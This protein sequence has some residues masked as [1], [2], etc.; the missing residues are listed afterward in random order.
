LAVAFLLVP[1]VVLSAGEVIEVR[2][3]RV[4]S[5]CSHYATFQSHNQKVVRNEKGIFMTYLWQFDLKTWWGRWQLLRSTDG[6]RTFSVIYTSGE[7]GSNAPCIETDSEN[8]ILLV[9]TDYNAGTLPIYYYRFEADRNYTDPTITTIRN[10]ASGKFS[11][12]LDED[13]DLLYIFNHYGRLLVRN[14]TTG[15]YVRQREVVE[16]SGEYA[17]TQYPHVFVD[18]KGTVHH[19]WTTQKKDLYL[20]WDIHYINSP[21]KGAYWY[22]AAGKKLPYE[23]RPDDPNQT[24]VIVLDDEFQYH[25]WLSNMIVKNG[26]VHFA[27]LAQVPPNWRQHYVRLDLET[28]EIDKRIQPLFKGETISLNGLDGFFAT[29]PGSSPL[30]YVARANYSHIGALVSYDNGD[31]WHDAAISEPIPHSIYSV[32]GCRELA[33]EGIMGSFTAQ[34][35]T[36]PETIAGDPHFFVIPVAE[37]PALSAAAILITSAGRHIRRRR[38]RGG[39]GHAPLGC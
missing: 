4:D 10:G 20:Y 16:T 35:G 29:G 15:G 23:I 6:G 32:G 8:N 27:Y 11:M 24:D 30:Y 9:C 5:N 31:T 1:P 2:L 36:Y 38:G 18:Q 28:G 3:T 14:A 25:T 22:T 33:P 13:A 34:Y 19:A 37:A 21:D 7:M 26:K 17:M 39:S 12:F